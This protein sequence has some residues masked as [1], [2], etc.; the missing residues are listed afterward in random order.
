MFAAAGLMLLNKIDLLPYLDFDVGVVWTM[1]DVLIPTFKFCN[2]P[3]VPVQDW[4][5]G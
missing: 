4:I 3:P 1:R 2:C 5:S